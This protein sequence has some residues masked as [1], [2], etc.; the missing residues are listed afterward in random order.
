MS[1]GKILIILSDADS[2]PVQ[3][4]DGSITNQETR[5]FL[6]ELAKLLQKLLDFGYDVTFASPIGKRP[7]VDPLSESLLVYFGNWLQRRRENALIERM[8]SENN[9]TNPR[10]FTSFTEEELESYAGVFIPGG[11]A[12]IRDLGDNPELGRIPLHFHQRGKP[13]AA[14]C[15]GPLALLSTKYALGSPGFAYQGYKLTSWSDAE[16]SLVEKLQGG[17]IPK[18]ESTLQ[19]EGADMI[20]TVGKKAGG[21]T[22]DREVVSGANPMAAEGLGSRFVEMLGA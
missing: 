11:H 8:K 12:P 19:A 4:P 13:T 17:Q 2:Y 22:C 18:V 9:L 1:A 3:K 7:S 6:T 10:S 16:E 15:H 5:F 14:I 21:I 20:S